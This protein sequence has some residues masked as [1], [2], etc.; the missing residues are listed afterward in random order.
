MAVDKTNLISL[1]VYLGQICMKLPKNEA[2]P[3]TWGIAPAP[4]R[5]TKET[6]K[7]VKKDTNQKEQ[8]SS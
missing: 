5:I 3:H 6:A 1:S 7:T 8:P 4:P 2:S